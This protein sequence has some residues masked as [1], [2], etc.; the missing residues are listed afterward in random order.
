MSSL[1]ESVRPINAIRVVRDPR[2]ERP[3]IRTGD[4]DEMSPERVEAKLRNL[5][6]ARFREKGYTESFYL[7]GLWRIEYERLYDSL[8]AV[9]AESIPF[10]SRVS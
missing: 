4:D 1:I 8:Q 9:I 5:L 2:P 7:A 6:E 10:L 3:P